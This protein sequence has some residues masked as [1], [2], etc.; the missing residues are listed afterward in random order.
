[1]IPWPRPRDGD[2]RALDG[3][4]DVDDVVQDTMLRVVHGLSGLRDPAAFRSWL[5]AIAIRQVRDRH[6]RHRRRA[7][8]AVPDPRQARRPARGRAALGRLRHPSEARQYAAVMHRTPRQAARIAI[9]TP[10]DA[11]FLFRYDNEEVGVHWAMPG[12][13]LD[14]GESYTEGAVREVH[15]ETGWTDLVPGPLLCT[16]EH[17]YTRMGVPVR[18]FEHVYLTRGPRREPTGDLAAAHAEDGIL[19]WQWWSPAELDACRDP[20]WPP[21]LPDLLAPLRGGSALAPDPVHLGYIPNLP[22]AR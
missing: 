17:D 21:R 9:L 16:W 4:A 6:R 15:E 8:P 18:Q 13:G 20:L 11:V 14:P 3:H 10:D 22:P 1:M 19:R 5:V 2:Q 12:G 7:R